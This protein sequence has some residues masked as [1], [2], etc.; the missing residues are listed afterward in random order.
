MG[1]AGQASPIHGGS[2]AQLTG[3]KGSAAYNVVSDTTA[4]LQRS[5]G[6]HNPMGQGRFDSKRGACTKQAGGHNVVSDRGIL[7][8]SGGIS[9]VRVFRACAFVKC[10]KNK[11]HFEIYS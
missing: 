1:C 2:T 5:S 8:Q 7:E 11:G 3:A 6:V 10:C 4:H 9:A